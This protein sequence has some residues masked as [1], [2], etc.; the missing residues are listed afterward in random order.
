VA[1]SLSRGK[2]K[3]R[4][5]VALR[6]LE[7]NTAKENSS[8]HSPKKG[9]VIKKNPFV[10]GGQTDVLRLKEEGGGSGKGD[11]LFLVAVVLESSSVRERERERREFV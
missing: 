9:E 1:L 4:K 6:R 5:E 8:H 2:G 11:F 3:G 10:I 7:G